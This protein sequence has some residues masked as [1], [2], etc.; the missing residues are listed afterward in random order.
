L[1]KINKWKKLTNSPEISDINHCLINLR[2]QEEQEGKKTQD[3]FWFIIF[4][5]SFNYVILQHRSIWKAKATKNCAIP[6]TLWLYAD[7][8]NQCKRSKKKRLPSRFLLF[9]SLSTIFSFL[10]SYTP[11]C[12]KI[13]CRHLPEE[14]SCV[15]SKDYRAIHQVIILD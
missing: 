9:L 6:K 13:K 4:Y 15:I 14:D 11:T 5:S 3:F 7:F 1:P 12:I 2:K 10:F 8:A